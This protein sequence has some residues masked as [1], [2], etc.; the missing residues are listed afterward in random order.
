MR[1]S[2]AVAASTMQ[3]VLGSHVK[4]LVFNGRQNQFTTGFQAG[5]GDIFVP[6]ANGDFVHAANR[7]LAR[8]TETARHAGE[9]LQFERNV[10]ENMRRPRTLFEA[11]QET[12]ALAVA[13]TVFD[14]RGQESLQAVDKTGQGVGREVFQFANIDDGFDDWSIGPDVWSA[15]VAD[16]KKLEV[17]GCHVVSV[18]TG[19][20]EPM[21]LR[22]D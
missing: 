8:L 5:A 10:F 12:T 9:V 4:R 13:T 18:G 1:R 6:G 20:S 2:L 3:P 14:Q 17:F 19:E 22:S 7:R 15:Q 16:F 11:A 21:K